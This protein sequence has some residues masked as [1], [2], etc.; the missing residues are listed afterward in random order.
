MKARIK[1]TGEVLIVEEVSDKHV[2]VKMP[3]SIGMSV[4]LRKEEV[5]ILQE[6]CNMVD[7]EQR[8]YEIAKDAMAAFISAPSYQFCANDNY[9]D[10][11]FSNANFLSDDAVKYA[12]AL[13]ERLK[14]GDVKMPDSVYMFVCKSIIDFFN[15][16]IVMCDSMTK[17]NMENRRMCIKQRCNDAIGFYNESKRNWLNEQG[18]EKENND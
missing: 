13:I 16:I 3:C 10:A 6:G 17:N 7:W 4:A 12:D 8:K 11:S 15:G 14:G 18:N 5:E 2:Y 9:Y 1:E